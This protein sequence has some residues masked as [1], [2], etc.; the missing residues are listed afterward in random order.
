[1]K[2]ATATR[3]DDP[4]LVPDSFFHEGVLMPSRVSRPRPPSPSFWWSRRRRRRFLRPSHKAALMARGSRV[5]REPTKNSKDSVN[6]RH[7]RSD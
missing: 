6:S 4:L 3:D 2:E 5:P 7:A 1:M